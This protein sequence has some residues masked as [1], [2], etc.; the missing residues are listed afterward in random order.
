MPTTYNMYFGPLRTSAPQAGPCIYTG[1][2]CMFPRHSSSGSTSTPAP[3]AAVL[4]GGT[5]GVAYSET[6]S[7][8][9]GTSPYTFA[10]T[11][12]SLPA[13][14]SLNSTTGVISGTPTTAGTSTFTIKCTDA[15]G[16]NSSFT[17]QIT[18]AAPA[19][20]GVS[21]SGFVG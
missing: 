5:I 19:A 10:V 14:L 1:T 11:S 16:S 8:V 18:I 21:N 13:G 12:G 15:T 2:V 20:G 4:Q 7:A 6:M 17:F 3:V 9:F